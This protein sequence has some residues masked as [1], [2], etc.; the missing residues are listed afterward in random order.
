MKSPIKKS[1]TAPPVKARLPRRREEVAS[2]E[3]LPRM[4]LIGRDLEILKALGRYRVL[5]TAQIEARLFNSASFIRLVQGVQALDKPVKSRCWNRL[6]L[7]YHHGYVDRVEQ[8]SRLSEGRRP[9][10]YYLSRK[11]LNYLIYQE[12]VEEE[13]EEV[14][15]EEQRNPSHL[16]LAHQLT[17]NT[18]RIAVELATEAQG[19]R[20]VRWLDEKTLKR[21]GGDKVTLKGER[22]RILQTSL[23]PDGCFTVDT[24]ERDFHFLLEADRSTETG[25]YST[26]GRRDFTHK[27]LAYGELF[28]APSSSE[29][30]SLYAR[31]YGGGTNLGRVLTITTGQRRADHLKEIAEKTGRKSKFWF[32]SLKD[33][34][35]ETIFTAPIWRIANREGLHALFE[36]VEPV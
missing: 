10:L 19:W 29:G 14:E 28:K 1:Q 9:Y 21:Q 35:P 6:Q 16:F 23:I 25:E 13:E 30:D 7:L 5:D 8:P 32:A 33:L 24:G 12:A 2:P 17:L 36:A 18:I 3:L 11:G 15:L 20:I 34:T 26:F 31:R 22:G 27:M 4:R